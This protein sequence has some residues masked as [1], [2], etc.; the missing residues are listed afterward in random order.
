MVSTVSINDAL[1]T[2]TSGIR[3]DLSDLL[4]AATPLADDDGIHFSFSNALNAVNHFHVQGAPNGGGPVLAVVSEDGEANVDANYATLGTGGFHFG[5]GSGELFAIT[6]YAGALH[7]TTKFSV[8]PGDASA[9]YPRLTSDDQAEFAV[10]LA[11]T[12]RFLTGAAPSL[13]V[14]QVG[15]SDPVN[16][17][18]VSGGIATDFVRITATGSDTNV[19]KYET[20]KGSGSHF[21]ANGSGNIAVFDSGGSSSARTNYF[22]FRNAA[23]GNAV[24]ILASVSGG[25]NADIQITPSG[26]GRVYAASPLMFK[27]G[28]SVAPTNNGDV[29]FE[30]TSNTS[31][32]IKAKGSDGTVRSSAAI[33]LS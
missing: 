12:L 14:D 2:P 1:V 7:P 3:R 29:I 17:L 13:V 24:Q 21:F 6:D 9:S 16:Y 11:K 32:T 25:G 10:P 23:A 4:A 20:N 15:V 8:R 28:S 5:N 27:P 18:R 26:T 33:T 19:S 31:F 22:V 30:L